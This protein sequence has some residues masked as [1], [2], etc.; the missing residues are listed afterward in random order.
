MLLLS[1]VFFVVFLFLSFSSTIVVEGIQIRSTTM[2]KDRIHLSKSHEHFQ[3]AAAKELHAPV[4]AG[5][6]G[7]PLYAGG[8]EEEDIFFHVRPLIEQVRVFLQ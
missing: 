3:Q 2:T 4:A 5:E 8:E 1:N 6:D 7:A